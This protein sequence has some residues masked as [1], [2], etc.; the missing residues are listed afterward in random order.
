MSGL[1]DIADIRASEVCKL[2]AILTSKHAAITLCVFSVWLRSLALLLLLLSPFI[3]VPLAIIM[4]PVTIHIIF[5]WL[6]ECCQHLG[7]VDTLLSGFLGSI[8]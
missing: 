4:I 1:N 7:D 2:P 5:L 3:Y 8:K 6:M